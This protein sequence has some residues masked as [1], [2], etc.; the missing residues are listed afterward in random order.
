MTSDRIR[1]N[2]FKPAWWLPGPHSQT[3]WPYLFRRRR[4]LKL[5]EERLELPDG[6]FIDLCWTDNEFG[7]LVVVFHGLEGNIKSPYANAIMA[8]IHKMGW[9]GVFM[10]FRGC[11]RDV[12]RLDRSYH[13]GDTA[14]IAYVIETLNSRFP[15]VPIIT[16]G[17]SL[18]G[19]AMLKY[20]G[21]RA[22]DTAVCAAVAVSVPYQLHDSAESLSTGFSRLYQWRLIR[23]L[24]NKIRRKF[25]GRQAPFD[26]NRLETMDTFY[27]FDDNITAPIHGFSGADDYYTKS[28]SLQY[29][30]DIKVPTLLLHALDDPFM[31]K[32][33]IPRHENLSNRVILEISER[34][35]HVGFVGGILPWKAEYWLETR[36]IEYMRQCLK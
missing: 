12:N 36:M 18:G 22:S 19:N 13:S 4:K 15:G 24:K 34:G 1:A 28:S 25:Q 20:L 2:H 5:K 3:L 17:Y 7:P 32:A 30:S 9:R 33:S 27:L 21:E 10:H 35:G 11:S 16:A 6:D 29:L 8:R 31:T 23:S 14:D 26:M